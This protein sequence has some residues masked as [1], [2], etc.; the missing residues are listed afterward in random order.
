MAKATQKRAAQAKPAVQ[1]KTT[2]TKAPGATSATAQG[3]KAKAAP[4]PAATSREQHLLN[5]LQE[6]HT[7]ARRAAMNPSQPGLGRFVDALD[8]AK[9][10]ASVAVLVAE[11]EAEYL[12]DTR[13]TRELVHVT[14]DSGITYSYD[15]TQSSSAAEPANRVVA[16][17]GVS[18]EPAGPREAARLTGFPSPVGQGSEPLDRGHLVAHAAGGTEDGINL[19]PQD[20][21][22]NRGTGT[23]ADKKRWRAIERDLS[24]RPGTPF[25]VRP[26]YV[27]DSDFPGALEFGVQLSDGTWEVP[28]FYNR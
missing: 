25:V 17:W 22:L 1:T 5:S 12:A 18:G 27:D 13:G 6:S 8:R 7:V 3:T 14:L 28:T 26:Q 21:E 15:A 20:R 24:R 11:R 10:S 2:R 9:R 19:I 4:V 16:V 23:D